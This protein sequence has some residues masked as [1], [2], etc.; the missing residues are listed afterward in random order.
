MAQSEQVAVRGWLNEQGWEVLMTYIL[1]QPTAKT[2]KHRGGTGGCII[3]W[4]GVGSINGLL[5]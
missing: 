4:A 2:G 5:S 1:C 3:I